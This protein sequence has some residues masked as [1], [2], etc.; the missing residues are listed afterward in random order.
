MQHVPGN[1]I[2][3]QYHLSLALGHLHV[4]DHLMLQGYLVSEKVLEVT[5]ERICCCFLGGVKK[6]TSPQVN[7]QSTAEP[8]YNTPCYNMVLDITLSC[9]GSQMLIFV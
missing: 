1:C 5:L 9:L 3:H 4:A 6:C 2:P 8:H 7:L